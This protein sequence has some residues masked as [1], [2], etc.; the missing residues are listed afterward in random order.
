MEEEKGLLDISGKTVW[1]VAALTVLGVGAYLFWR[2][3]SKKK[4]EELAAPALPVVVS[5][6]VPSLKKPKK[7]AAR[8]IAKAQQQAY[9]G[10]A[11]QS[12]PSVSS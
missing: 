8:K 6:D 4:R 9:G 7:Q 10:A 3:Y 5:A 2:S 11:V 1:G 12:L